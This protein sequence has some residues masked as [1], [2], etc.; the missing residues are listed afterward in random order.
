V[1]DLAQRS[2][3]IPA[4]VNFA[5]FFVPLAGRYLSFADLFLMFST[6]RTLT[7]CT[8]KHTRPAHW[9]HVAEIRAAVNAILHQPPSNIIFIYHESPSSFHN[10]KWGHRFCF[11]VNCCRRQR[12]VDIPGR[13]RRLSN[14]GGTEMKKESIGE[15]LA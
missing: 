13:G 11:L 10:Q 15:A 6:N 12:G 2:I 14:D 7:G 3:S 1:Q 9:L 4:L 8:M 5:S